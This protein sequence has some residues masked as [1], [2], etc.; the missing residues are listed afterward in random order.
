M[1]FVNFIEFNTDK[2]KALSIKTSPITKFHT[3][4][5]VQLL[6][7]NPLPYVQTTN[8]NGGINL[9]D[10]TV[11]VL[12]LCGN[13]KTIKGTSNLL[14][15][16]ND[17]TDAVWQNTGLELNGERI[18]ATNSNSP[19]WLEQEITK[20]ASTKT[21]TA[22]I[23]VKPAEY[24]KLYFRVSDTNGYLISYFDTV[25]KTFSN[26]SV[27]SFV[28]QEL[29][30]TEEDNGWFRVALKFTST[31][32]TKIEFVTGIVND[33]N[34]YI[35]I[36]DN[37]NGTNLSGLLL[38]QA[39]LQEGVLGAYIE[40]TASIAISKDIEGV[41]ITDSFLVDRI[42]HDTNGQSQFDWK[43]TNVPH[44][45]GNE[46]VYLKA[47][48]TIGETFYSNVF[49]LTNYDNEKTCRLDYKAQESSTMQSI[50]LQMY[51]WQQLKQTEINSYYQVSTRNTVT[52]LV[53]SQKYERWITDFIPNDLMIKIDDVFENKFVYVDL[54]RANLFEANEI[55]EFEA[56]EDFKE[57]TIKL[58]FIKSEI[59]N[60]LY[61]DPEQNTNP[62]ILLNSVT[63]NGINAIYHFIIENFSP[64]EL[65]FQTSQDQQTWNSTNAGA[66]NTQSITFSGTGTW[67]FRIIHPEAESNI[68]Q[69]DLGSTVVANTDNVQVAKGE[70][71]DINALFNDVLV[72]NTTI[73][74][75]TQPLNGTASIIDSGTKVRYVHND[76]ATSFDSLTYTISNGINSD[77]AT[78]NIT[79][80]AA[81]GDSTPFSISDTSSLSVKQACAFI[82]GTV[83]W[84]NGSDLNPMLNDFVFNDEGLTTP[85]NGDSRWFTISGGKIVKINSSGKVIDTYICG[86]D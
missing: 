14:L 44:D 28:N 75:V 35:F 54:I 74:S 60:P 73:T 50:Q 38:K 21:Y 10:W 12:K 15:H 80:T 58:S 62:L 33:S 42:F 39:Q 76:S 7:N 5:G 55:K 85:L 31:N 65:I 16:S 56:E 6:P 69:L 4:T 34:D 67:Y 79:I 70:S 26:T 41:D 1:S 32:D 66:T 86:F 23:Y 24:S 47:Q 22:S 48:Q 3:F 9:E 82:L 13:N 43:I 63:V 18:V 30:Y 68:V 11:S 84:H 57:N 20:E 8:V 19:H 61:E 29:S 72:G 2:E 64:K 78:I 59:Y 17:K 51:Y 49:Q 52:T 36:G 53:K 83:K 71:V 37:L 77:T 25:T 27:D 40:T 45:F 81:E 46:L